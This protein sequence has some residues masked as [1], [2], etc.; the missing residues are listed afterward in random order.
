[1]TVLTIAANYAN[2]DDGSIVA[3]AVLFPSELQ[4]PSFAYRNGRNQVK[5]EPLL[6]DPRRVP[7]DLTERMREYIYTVSHAWAVIPSTAPVGDAMGLAVTRAVERW[8]HRGFPL[9]ILRPQDTTILVA[10][11]HELPGA[12]IRHAPQQILPRFGEWHLGAAW[13]LAASMP[14]M[15]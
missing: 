9:P 10:G 8:A 14:E 7:E 2:R 4:E 13:F 11:P 15:P 5:Q 3:A 1:M 6:R 12:C